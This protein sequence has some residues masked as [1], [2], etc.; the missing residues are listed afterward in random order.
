MYDSGFLWIVA[1][2]VFVIIEAVTY[3]LISIWFVFG[4][5]VGLFISLAGLSVGW[6]M[7]IFL[8]VSL[9]LIIALRPVSMKLAKKQTFK[10][11]VD[12]MIGKE[13]LIT[14]QVNNNENSG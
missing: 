8:A 6:Q 7:G 14:V 3:Q 11:N 5:T 12:G 2:L 10:S 9:I 13:V 1:I 4:A